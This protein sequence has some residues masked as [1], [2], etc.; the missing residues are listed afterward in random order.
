MLMFQENDPFHFGSLGK[1]FMTI[2]RIE[3]LQVMYIFHIYI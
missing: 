3:T 1:A 2:Y